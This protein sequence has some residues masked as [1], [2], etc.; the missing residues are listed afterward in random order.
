MSFLVFVDA[1]AQSRVDT[2]AKALSDRPGLNL[3]IGG[4]GDPAS[5]REALRH[6]TVDIAMKREK[7]KSLAAAG[8]APASIE[9]ITIGAEERGKWLKAAYEAAPIKTRPRNVIGMLKDVP[10]AEMEAMLLAEAA[11]DEDAVRLLANARAQAVKDALASKGIA[12]ERLFLLAPRLGGEQ[13][14]TARTAVASPSAPPTRV[15]LALR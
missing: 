5:D 8:N 9:Q 13:A 14:A 6:G 10:D 4:R 7:M 1:E 11:V 12:G 15:D 2:L 3:E